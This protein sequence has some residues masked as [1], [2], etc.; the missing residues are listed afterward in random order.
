MAEYSHEVS[1]SFKSDAAKSAALRIVGVMTV[2]AALVTVLSEPIVRAQPA[3]R[4]APP[5]VRVPDE[6]AGIDGVVGA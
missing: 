5:N 6:A 3:Q 1:M 4:E 2:A